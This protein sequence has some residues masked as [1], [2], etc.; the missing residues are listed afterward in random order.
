MKIDKTLFPVHTNTHTID[1]RNAKVLLRPEPSEGAKGKSVVIGE[2][3][4]KN[5]DDKI[6]A[7]KVVL[8]KVS[9]GKELIKITIKAMCPGGKKVLLLLQVGLLSTIDRSNRF[10]R[11]IRPKADSGLSSPSARKRVLGSRT[12]Q[13]FKER[14]LPRNQPLASF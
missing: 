9:D 13:R 5:V 2:T 6:L 8:E 4:P 3:R 10:H 1:L 11:P 14:L 7:R 12:C